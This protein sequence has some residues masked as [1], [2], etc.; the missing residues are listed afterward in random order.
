MIIIRFDV[1]DNNYYVHVDKKMNLVPYKK[2]EEP[3][4]GPKRPKKEPKKET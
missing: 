3:K 4:E 2:K 1:N